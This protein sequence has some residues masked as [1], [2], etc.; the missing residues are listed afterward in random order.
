MAL[1]KVADRFTAQRPKEENLYSDFLVNLNFHPDNKQLMR[2]TNEE[3]VIRSIRNLLLTNKY[4]RLFNPRLG[5]NIQKLLFEPI[6][7]QTQV[8]IVDQVRETIE[9]FEPRAKLIDVIAT[10]YPDQNA[11][12]ITIIF[13]ITTIEN[14]ITI[15]I[16]LQR[17]R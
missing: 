7:P 17:V 1:P 13:F 15:N 12:V 9:N 5:S 6:S 3:A 4:E 16:P 11:Y 14:A 10:P 8:G 2:S